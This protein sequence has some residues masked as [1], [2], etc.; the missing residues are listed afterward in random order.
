MFGKPDWF[1][2]KRNRWGISPVCWQGWSYTAAW[3]G[4]LI[5]PFLM[6]IGDRLVIESLIW[7]T[8]AMGAFVWDVRQILAAIRPVVKD[9]VLYIDET[10]TLSEQFATRNYDFRLRG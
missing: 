6:L 7:L 4:I 8:A 5:L 1:E 2:T 10:E 3:A 9:D